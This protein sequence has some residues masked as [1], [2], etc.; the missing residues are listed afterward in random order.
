MR[1]IMQSIRRYLSQLMIF[2]AF[3]N[4][5]VA[6]SVLAGTTNTSVEH[7]IV[8]SKKSETISSEVAANKAVD[9]MIAN[10]CECIDTCLQDHPKYINGCYTNYLSTLNG[11]KQTYFTENSNSEEAEAFLN[12][13]KIK[14][15]SCL[16]RFTGVI[17]GQAKGQTPVIPA[18]G[19]KEKD[20]MLAANN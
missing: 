11:I 8:E 1:V 9:H 17:P 3:T 15:A 16:N 18:L 20:N 2:L 10:F 6:I 13:I 7:T 19:D 12:Q 4:P 14:T 5:L